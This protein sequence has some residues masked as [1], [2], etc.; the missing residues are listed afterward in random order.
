[1]KQMLLRVRLRDLRDGETEEDQK[2][3][4]NNLIRT[5]EDDPH[6]FVDSV[7]DIKETQVHLEVIRDK[8]TLSKFK[9]EEPALLI[10]SE[11]GQFLEPKSKITLNRIEIILE[12]LIKLEETKGPVPIRMSILK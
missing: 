7:S 4:L 12:E 2:A 11:R 8:K 1:M 9:I 6:H 10:Q 3:I 5:M